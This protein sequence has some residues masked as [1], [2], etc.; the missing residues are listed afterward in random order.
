MNKTNNIKELWAKHTRARQRRF[1]IAFNMEM[2]N[3]QCAN[4]LAH[5]KE[6]VAKIPVR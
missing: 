5:C 6:A 3:Q 4:L 2:M 1:E